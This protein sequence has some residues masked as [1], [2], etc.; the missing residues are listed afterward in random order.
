MFVSF[1]GV[2]DA[3]MAKHIEKQFGK[4]VMEMGK[5]PDVIEVSLEDFKRLKYELLDP[6]GV[7]GA[8]DFSLKN[9]IPVK[10]H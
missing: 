2:K 5:A 1:E 7:V 8:T 10:I 6:R 9:G 3:D 4:Y